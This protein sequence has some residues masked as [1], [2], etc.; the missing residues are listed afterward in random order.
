MDDFIFGTLSTDS[1]RIQ[2]VQNRLRGVTHTSHAP[3][4]PKPGEEITLQLS[5]GPDQP[6]DHAWV[7]WTTNQT[8]PEGQMGKAKRGLVTEMKETGS[9]WELG[10]WG[11]TRTFEVTLPAQKPETVLRYRLSGASSCKGEIF[12]DN[13]TYYALYIDHD[14]PPE[15]SREAI[16]Y[17]IFSDRFSPGKD[18]P[19]L[20]TNNLDALFG[21]TLMG[22]TDRLDYLEN[23][24]ITVIWFTPIFPSETYHRYD[25]T[26]VYDIDPRMG[27]KEDFKQL[28]EHAHKRGIRILLDLVPNHW[29]HKHP[30]F[31]DAQQNP[32][33]KYH[34]WYTFKNWPNDYE[35]FFGSRHMPKINLRNTEARKYVIDAA[36]FWLKFGVDGFRVDYA[37]GPTP[38][39]WA[40]LRKATRHVNKDSWIFGESVDDADTLLSFDGLMDGSLDFPLLEGFRNAFGFA[41]WNACHLARY[42]DDLEMFYPDEF[43]RPSF[44]D[45]HDM[46]RFS[47]IAK[48]DWSRL[49]LAS[50]CQFTLKQPPILYYGT[51]VGLSQKRDAMQGGRVLH[52]EARLPM[53]W[54]DAQNRPL[55]DYFQNLISFRKQNPLIWMGKRKTL[56]SD[57]DFW[58]YEFSMKKNKLFICLN[59]SPN[60]KILPC[61]LLVRNILFTSHG[62]EIRNQHGKWIVPGLSGFVA[63]S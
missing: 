33:S 40:D 35:C 24:G 6:A 17:Q 50:L 31:L 55:L 57:A 56:Y 51:E 11:F 49:R 37:I 12:A 15:W 48:N 38:D 19:W 14:E 5:I 21:G 22:V 3:Q 52:S 2:H 32:N 45:N 9:K 25:A 36:L 16:L 34:N 30:T 47:W 42:I 20:Q 59:F 28:L 23:L 39:F 10:I 18:K 63:K 62:G 26:D 29:S 44:I 54:G 1:L 41:N 53:L 60:E 8:D 61:E 43:Q 13:G 27:T 58:V 4:D 7:Y 46:N